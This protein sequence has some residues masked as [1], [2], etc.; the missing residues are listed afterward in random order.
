MKVLLIKD[1]KSLGKAG[2][3][4][5][6]ADGYGKNFLIGKGLALHATNE[7]L[8]RHNAEQKKAKAKEED[9]IKEAKELAEKL[10]STKLTIRHKVG[11]NGH[12]IGSVTNK[13]VSEEL[14]KQFSIMIDKKSITVDNKLKTVGIYEV[15]CK[16][17]H[18]I[19]ATLKI[20]IIAG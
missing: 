16:L 1:V 9:E 5:E 3:I 6:V 13:E 18:S 20:D 10:N 2:E 7:V 15:V 19:S 4:K 14:E 11:A 8:A 12:L 17:G